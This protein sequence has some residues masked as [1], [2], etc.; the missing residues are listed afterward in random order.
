MNVFPMMAALPQK[1]IHVINDD[2]AALQEK[3]LLKSEH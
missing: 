3:L 1:V 2:Y